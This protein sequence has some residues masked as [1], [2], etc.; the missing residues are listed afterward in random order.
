MTTLMSRTEP[1][2]ALAKKSLNSVVAE[3][4]RNIVVRFNR[5]SWR[6]SLMGCGDRQ[7]GRR[8]TENN[9]KIKK[10]ITGAKRVL[11]KLILQNPNSWPHQ[12]K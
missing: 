2:R 8:E 3:R 5:Q 10:K 6:C 12:W 4:T 1:F 7:L 11:I 9:K